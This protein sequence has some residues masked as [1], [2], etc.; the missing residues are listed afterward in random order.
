MSPTASHD[1]K[2]ATCT[3][4]TGWIHVGHFCVSNLLPVLSSPSQMF[5]IL[6]CVVYFE[7]EVLEYIISSVSV[8]I[9]Q[10]FELAAVAYVAALA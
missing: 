5:F 1:Y 9:S 8:Q 6:L 3:C 10:I 4:L 7:K 2:R